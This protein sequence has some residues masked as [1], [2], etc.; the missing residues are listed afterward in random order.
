[1]MGYTRRDRII[2]FLANKN[3]K[4]VD[5]MEQEGP[6][7]EALEEYFKNLE[8]ETKLLK[9]NIIRTRNVSRKLRESYGNI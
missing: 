5:K 6:S 4:L 2:S 7:P 9:Q 3:T 1:M 8:S